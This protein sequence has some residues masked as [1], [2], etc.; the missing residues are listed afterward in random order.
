MQLHS[1]KEQ[2]WILAITFFNETQKDRSKIR[3]LFI[4]GLNVHKAGKLLY[5]R[6]LEYELKLVERETYTAEPAMT[7]NVK[8]CYEQIYKYL[9]MILENLKGNCQYYFDILKVLDDFHF[10]SSI[11]DKFIDQILEVYGKEACVWDNLAQRELLG[12]HYKPTFEETSAEI[13]KNLCIAKYEEGLTKVETDQKKELWSKFLKYL[14]KGTTYYENIFVQDV[15]ETFYLDGKFEQASAEGQLSEEGY[16]WW[17]EMNELNQK[18]EYYGVDGSN[19]PVIERYKEMDRLKD[20]RERE[21]LEKGKQ[22][23][24]FF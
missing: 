4:D 15:S 5:K 18:I 19:F 22:L 12:L 16:F 13:Q 6:A 24:V 7:D 8:Q 17:L 2:A 11:T 10:T 1:D 3:N 14:T 9:S 21:I 20:M 23:K